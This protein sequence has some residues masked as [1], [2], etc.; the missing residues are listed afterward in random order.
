MALKESEQASDSIHR[1]EF[2]H[3]DLAICDAAAP[4][5]EKSAHLS[6]ALFVGALVV[7]QGDGKLALRLN[8]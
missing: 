5:G 6:I 2:K 3:S 7:V 8:A 1:P 4:L